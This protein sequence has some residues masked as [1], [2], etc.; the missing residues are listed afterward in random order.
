[1]FRVCIQSSDKV[2]GMSSGAHDVDVKSWQ[3]M[4]QLPNFLLEQ[5]QTSTVE[6][7]AFH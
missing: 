3:G 5:A 7:H 6:D 2:T 4:N 1:M